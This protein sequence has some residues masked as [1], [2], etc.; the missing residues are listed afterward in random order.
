MN[1]QESLNRDYSPYRDMKN[2]RLVPDSADEDENMEQTSPA[3]TRGSSHRI[4]SPTT[5]LAPVMDERNSM[6]VF[7][8]GGVSART[9]YDESETS[10]FPPLNQFDRASTDQPKDS[11]SYK[12]KEMQALFAPPQ[13]LDESDY[14]LLRVFNP[15][16]Y[17][18]QA[19]KKL[20]ADKI[21]EMQMNKLKLELSI[22]KHRNRLEYSKLMRQQPTVP[23]ASARR[24]LNPARRLNSSS[25][26][27]VESFANDGNGNASDDQT[28][29]M[30]D[31]ILDHF[32]PSSPQHASGANQIIVV[33]PS[34]IFAPSSPQHA[35]GAN[36]IIVVKPS[37]T[38]NSYQET[39][40]MVESR[41]LS[42]TSGMLNYSQQTTA[43]KVADLTVEQFN[44]IT[45]KMKEDIKRLVQDTVQQELSADNKNRHLTK[46]AQAEYIQRQH[47]GLSEKIEQRVAEKIE[48]LKND[49]STL[50]NEKL[51]SVYPE[52]ASVQTSHGTEYNV[53]NKANYRALNTPSMQMQ[54]QPPTYQ[55]QVPYPQ[56]AQYATQ[57]FP[58]QLQQQQQ[59]QYQEQLRGD[60]KPNLMVNVND[61]NGNYS[62][63]QPYNAQQSYS[64][65]QFLQWN[66]DN[67][68]VQYQQLQQQ[69]QILQQ[70]RQFY[71][72]LKSNNGDMRAFNT[73]NHSR[74]EISY[75]ELDDTLNLENELQSSTISIEEIAASPPSHPIPRNQN[76]RNRS[77]RTI[78]GSSSH[79]RAS[80]PVVSQQPYTPRPLASTHPAATIS[81]IVAHSPADS[82]RNSNNNNSNNRRA[83]TQYTGRKA[84]RASNPFPKIAE[85][86]SAMDSSE[87][88]SP[89]KK[90]VS[91]NLVT[92]E[93]V[94]NEQ[95]TTT[96]VLNVVAEELSELRESQNTFND[97]DDS[98]SLQES[99]QINVNKSVES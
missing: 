65:E 2:I 7:G 52:S 14:T 62:Q 9:Y 86:D 68:Q 24:R 92:V 35:S 85:V 73:S 70:P 28:L 76:S 60:L 13:N 30:L 37:P 69:Q 42:R 22:H 5:T 33:K 27:S 91:S 58:Q 96:Q 88:I 67:S 78:D 74:S 98:P 55:Q 56:Q 90:N 81:P 63:Q 26:D 61:S 4:R 20:T 51:A 40:Y 47:Q 36:Q 66:W 15:V 38:K 19:K 79:R 46:R 10:N 72:P 31:P 97:H 94:S 50:R 64:N 59:F 84:S 54:P 16:K 99:V 87:S 39:V 75:S 45:E 34:P 8:S 41:P 32:A 89:V 23:A 17:P 93:E 82:P 43:P 44:Q 95:N 3:Y 49:L 1:N 53:G 29:R 71:Q 48:A 21:D 18:S 25:H 83:S 12:F 6:F 77:R 11:S 57:Q 80:N